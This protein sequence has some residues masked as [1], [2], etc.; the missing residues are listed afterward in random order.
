MAGGGGGA[1]MLSGGAQLEIVVAA[2]AE[3]EINR[4]GDKRGSG[5]QHV[6]LKARQESKA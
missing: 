6:A 4:T 5:K 2:V 1:W 3:D